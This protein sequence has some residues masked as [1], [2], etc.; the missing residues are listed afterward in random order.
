VGRGAGKGECFVM[1][2]TKTDGVLANTKPTAPAAVFPNR[3][4]FKG[5]NPTGL[6]LSPDEKTLYV[7]NGGTNSVAVIRLEQDLDDSRVIG[8]IPTGWYPNAISLSGDGALL[9]VVNGKSNA[10]PNRTG[11]R[12]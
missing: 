7:T 8:L 11:C 6:A 1:G 2:D 3:D 5:S 10:G 12:N 4:G 9:Y